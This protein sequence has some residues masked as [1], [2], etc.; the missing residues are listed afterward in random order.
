M[1]DMKL[2]GRFLEGLSWTIDKS[3]Q[4]Y[5]ANYI[6]T[7]G[8]LGIFMYLPS[9]K[10]P[11]NPSRS[12]HFNLAGSCRIHFPI[13]VRLSTSIFA[14]YHLDA[15]KRTFLNIPPSPTKRIHFPNLVFD[16]GR[17]RINHDPKAKSRSF[18]PGCGIST[19]WYGTGLSA[20]WQN[21][22]GVGDT[23]GMLSHRQFRYNKYAGGGW[24]CLWNSKGFSVFPQLVV[25]TSVSTRGIAKPK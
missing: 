13:F 5:E 12:P 24:V 18:S 10:N 20:A 22:E 8:W 9:M 23:I 21:G 17:R 7:L 3:D 4:E 15:S 11:G 2:P 16:L 25:D 19:P 14:K 6:R 1:G